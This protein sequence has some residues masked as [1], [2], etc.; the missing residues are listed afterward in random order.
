MR[1]DHGNG[2]LTLTM[3]C[4]PVCSFSIT[5]VNAEVND[6]HANVLAITRVRSLRRLGEA[7]LITGLPR[8]G[9]PSPQ[10]DP[11]VLSGIRL[12]RPIMG[13]RRPAKIGPP[14]ACAADLLCRRGRG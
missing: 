14:I 8:A 7:R 13:Q 10:A 5:P 6:R 3:S 4:V 12:S 9:D 11:A 1:V 2:L